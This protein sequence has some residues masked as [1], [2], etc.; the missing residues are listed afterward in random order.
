MKPGPQSPSTT[1]EKSPTSM[2]AV[3]TL[4]VARPG[5]RATRPLSHMNPLQLAR[6]RP[7]SSLRTAGVVTAA[8]DASSALAVLTAVF[9]ASATRPR[10][11]CDSVTW[12]DSSSSQWPVL[13]VVVAGSSHCRRV[14]KSPGPRRA[15]LRSTAANVLRLVNAAVA[16]GPNDETLIAWLDVFD[17]T[18]GESHSF[19]HVLTVNAWVSR[20]AARQCDGVRQRATENRS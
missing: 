5:I 10:V 2:L 8:M 3:G 7:D 18:I 14:R 15:R 11:D 17:R 19:A 13:V 6:S 16:V 1:S 20:P 9:G 4:G 12:D